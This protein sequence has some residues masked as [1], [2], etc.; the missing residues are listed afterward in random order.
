MAMRRVDALRDDAATE[1]RDAA[2]LG[3]RVRPARA[4]EVHDA[5]Q[6]GDLVRLGAEPQGGLLGHA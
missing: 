5:E 3:P 2:D 4:D 1:P 6:A